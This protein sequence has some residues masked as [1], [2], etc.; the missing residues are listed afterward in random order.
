MQPRAVVPARQCPS[1]QPLPPMGSAC[2]GQD[3]D[4]GAQKEVSEHFFLS[5]MVKETRG[6]K[7]G[8][9]LLSILKRVG[10]SLAS[11]V[12]GSKQSI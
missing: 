10:A 9:C 5:V 1:P 12:E 11:Q 7:G 8:S 4:T 2:G 3:T 6:G